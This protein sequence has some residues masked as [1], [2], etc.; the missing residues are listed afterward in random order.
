MGEHYNF[1]HSPEKVT[2]TDTF[3]SITAE[4]PSRSFLAQQHKIVSRVAF[5]QLSCRGADRNVILFQVTM[6]P[7]SVCRRD[8]PSVYYSVV[9]I[10]PT[11]RRVLAPPLLDD[12]L[13]QT[14]REIQIRSVRCASRD[15]TQPAAVCD[16][17]LSKQNSI[18]HTVTAND[19]TVLCCA[20][21]LS[22]THVYLWVLYGLDDP[23][24][25]TPR[26]VSPKR[27]QRGGGIYKDAASVEMM[28]QPDEKYTHSNR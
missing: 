23:P 4:Y 13:T 6:S 1:S 8:A 5:P 11:V 25:H 18:A 21:S 28:M 24:P 16:E 22:L 3:S 15:I 9:T 26:S 17:Q 12:G 27:Q 20:L 14:N 10:L 7:V 2:N 19:N